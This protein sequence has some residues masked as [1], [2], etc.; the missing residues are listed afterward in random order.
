[1]CWAVAKR[2]AAIAL[3]SGASHGSP[4]ASSRISSSGHTSRSGS[5]GSYSG[6][7][8]DAAATAADVS[9]RGNGKSTF[10]Q[11]PSLRPGV[12]PSAPAIRCVSQ[13]SIPRVG[14]ATSSGANGSCGGS[15]SRSRSALMR[16]S[17]RSERWTWSIQR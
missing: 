8:P 13:R 17:A 2:R 5:H 9:L 1:M 7:I 14:T 10:A 6:S 4:S 15:A 11:M 3:A 16:P 12:A